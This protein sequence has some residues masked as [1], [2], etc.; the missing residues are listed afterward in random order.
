MLFYTIMQLSKR[1]MQILL[2]CLISE[3][4]KFL[5]C[6]RKNAVGIASLSAFTHK[7]LEYFFFFLHFSSSV[8]FQKKFNLIGFRK[9]YSI[10][11]KWMYHK[12]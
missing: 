9:S 11:E 1:K 5:L 12:M 2:K 4:S 8:I 10:N 7:L 6:L 3:M